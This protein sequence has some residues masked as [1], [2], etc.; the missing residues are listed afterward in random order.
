MLHHAV[1]GRCNCS[2]GVR[3][4][5]R[6]VPLSTV[7]SVAQMN[8]EELWDVACHCSMYFECVDKCTTHLK[9]CQSLQVMLLR[10]ASQEFRIDIW[11]H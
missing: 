9:L 5:A 8:R 3:P 6:M 11:L 4:C 2:A 1:Q 7:L 10:G